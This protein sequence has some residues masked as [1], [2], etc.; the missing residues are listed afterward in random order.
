M[1]NA[2]TERLRQAIKDDGRAM[3]AIS[4]DA[5][6]GPE[7]ALFVYTGVRADAETIEMLNLLAEAPED[8]RASALELLKNMARK[9]Q[10]PH[11]EGK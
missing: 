8:L 2:W 11:A 9:L 1:K 3:R 10:P 6:L 5:G 4:L 7:A